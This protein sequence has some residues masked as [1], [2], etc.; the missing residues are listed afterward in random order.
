MNNNP[1]S[2]LKKLAG[3]EHRRV[4]SASGLDQENYVLTWQDGSKTEYSS[5]EDL[6]PHYQKIVRKLQKKG[7]NE[8]AQFN[9][10]PIIDRSPQKKRRGGNRFRL[11]WRAEQD[12]LV[13]LWPTLGH[14]GSWSCLS[15]IAALFC[16]IDFY[17]P[18]TYWSKYPGISL[19]VVIAL[20]T[21]GILSLASAFVLEERF[22]IHSNRVTLTRWP[23][24]LR[25]ARVRPR[26]DL[27]NARVV[28]RRHAVKAY[29]TSR[30][31]N[32]SSVYIRVRTPQGIDWWQLGG[33]MTRGNAQSLGDVLKYYVELDKEDHQKDDLVFT[34]PLWPAKKT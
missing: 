25:P 26:K 11:H 2:S 30:S 28:L 29:H 31:Y 22:E 6:P 18:F 10:S 5:L 7:V 19:G 14:V 4:R 32:T 21:L 9:T 23:A 33:R 20:A 24:F 27:I 16:S 8:N 34:I 1:K 3:L 17:E 13:I 12:K 15:I